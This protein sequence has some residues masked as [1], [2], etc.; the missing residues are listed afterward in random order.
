AKLNYREQMLLEKRNA[1]CMTCGRVSPLSTRS[2]FEEL[3]VLFEGSSA[4]G[5][6]RAYARA[7]DRLTHNLVEDG[8]LCVVEL[9]RKS[10]RK[11][12]KKIAVAVYEYRADYDGEWGE[13]QFDFVQGIAEILK[14]AELDTVKS[15]TYAKR[16]ISH[17]LSLP[18]DDLPKKLT[19]P[20]ER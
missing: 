6:E 9:K 2:T 11:K 16:V 20:F 1:I 8:A 7:L 3:A 17:I 13:I 4:S 18:V 19:L 12:G 10:Q 5:A 15:N 14:L